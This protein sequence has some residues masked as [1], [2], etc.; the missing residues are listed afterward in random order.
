MR[1]R[2]FIQNAVMLSGAAAKVSAKYQAAPAN[3][4]NALT[5]AVQLGN[6]IVLYQSPYGS[7][8]P[9]IGPYRSPGRASTGIQGVGPPVRALYRL[10]QAIGE[11][12]YKTAADR[13]ATYLMNTIYDPPTPYSSIMTIDGH[14]RHSLSAAWMYGKALSPCFEWFSLMNP[15][16]GAYELKAYALHR[17]LQRHRRADSYFGVGYPTG[18][19]PDAQFSCDLGEVGTGL[20]GFYKITGY[21]PALEDAFGLAKF[22]LTDYQ[23]GSGK[24]VWSPRLGVWLVGPWPGSGAEHFTDQQFNTTAWGW[25][26][27]VVGEFLLRLREHTN[28]SSL[29]ADIDAKCV[30]AMRWCF[31]ACQ[32]EDGAHGMFGRD[33]KWVGQGAAA[34]LLYLQL[35][36]QNAIPPD[37]EQRYRPKIE[38]SWRWLLANTARDTYPTDGYIRIT[39]KTSKKPPENLLWMMAWT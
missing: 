10:H 24:G 32:F 35:K 20:M 15:N 19:Y 9:V 33:D 37:V 25:S 38:K 23:E 11:P 16:E 6:Q 30:S 1:R 4:P 17:W 5:N 12:V 2:H 36:G 8:D 26:A 29:R 22:F 27:L 18:K 7:I 3:S 28:D 14:S 13:F 39:G 21:R 31:D 34:I